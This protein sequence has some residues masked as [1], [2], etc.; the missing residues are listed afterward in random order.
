MGKVDFG[1][2]V[3]EILFN[4]FN[5]ILATFRV[6]RIKNNIHLGESQRHNL[7]LLHSIMSLSKRD[8]IARN[9]AIAL[10]LIFHDRGNQDGSRK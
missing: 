2:E 10:Q 7:S 6:A 9:T 3:Y 8:V 5:F 1:I 4:D